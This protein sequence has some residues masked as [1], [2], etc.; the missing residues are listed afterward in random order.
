MQEGVCGGTKTC[1]PGPTLEWGKY[2][3]VGCRGPILRH[4]FASITLR[5]RALLSLITV[6]RKAEDL[7][8]DR[9]FA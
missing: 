2:V 8:I 4:S 7:L 6:Y 1:Q 3:A 9:R 5:A